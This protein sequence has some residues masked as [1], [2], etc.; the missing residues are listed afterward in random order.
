V[1]NRKIRLAWVSTYNSRCGLATHSEHLLEHFDR[2][3]YDITII[4]N[5]EEPVRPDPANLVRL[6]P[7]RSGSLA[8]VRDFIRNFDAVFVNFPFS[9]MEVHDL[10][11]LLHAAQLAAIDTYVTLH[12][13]IDTLVDGRL[14][15][16]AE[17][18]DVLGS[19][20]R[21]IVHTEADIARLKTFGLGDNVVMIPPGVV[22]RP[23]LST[24]MV[25]SLLGLPQAGPII[26]TFGFLLPPKGLQQLIHAFALVRRH[27]PEATLLMLNA[28]YPGAVE[29]AE[30][31][32]R[33]LILIAELG[34]ED[35]VRLIGEFLETDEILLLL[36]ACDLT[37]FA[38]QESD[39]SDGGAVRL[40]L[41]A[42]RPVVTTPLP[43]FAN[44]AGVVHQVAA[45]TAAD[46][47]EAIVALLENADFAERV[48]R[49]QHD[50]VSR[51]SWAAQAARV[52]NIIR[53]SFEER[54]GVA[55]RPPA[56]P[57]LASEEV[58]TGASATATLR[59][60]LAL[61]D[62]VEPSKLPPREPDTPAIDAADW[63]A[64]HAR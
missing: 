49:R 64:R 25:R 9:L 28:E 23:A 53:G 51:N 29:S 11:A 19:C 62:D 12:K 35:S 18:A 14:V 22:D 5:H 39:E 61:I 20:T 10:A 27:A 8:S 45:S 60:M 57:T 54:H 59:E 41:A 55:L 2:Q 34:L 15:S 33:C 56:S 13:T 6:W 42:G 50:W 44:L 24:P 3:L 1:M 4:G 26:G 43:V 31:R 46:I 21:L 36:N 7:D 16:L 52:G 38:Y 37:A 58:E 17:I 48:V 40:G 63:R 32:Q 30:E 47:A